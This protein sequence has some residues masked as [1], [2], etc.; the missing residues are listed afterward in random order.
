MDSTAVQALASGA[1]AIAT[2][3]FGYLVARHTNKK[4]LQ[5]KQ[6]DS[7]SKEHAMLRKEFREDIQMLREELK[8]WRERSL[9]LEDEIKELEK[10]NQGLV[11]ENLRL[12]ARVQE[13]E[14]DLRLFHLSNSKRG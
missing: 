12:Q 10:T 8:M 2:G 13:L 6:H 1:G 11:Q 7:F 9:R 5:M 14:N 3:L 4:E